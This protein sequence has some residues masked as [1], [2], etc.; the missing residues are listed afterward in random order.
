MSTQGRAFSEAVEAVLEHRSHNGRPEATGERAIEI[1]QQF[2]RTCLHGAKVPDALA[3]AELAPELRQLYQDRTGG[4]ELEVFHFLHDI[5]GAKGI[6]KRVVSE[7]VQTLTAAPNWSIALELCPELLALVE[8]CEADAVRPSLAVISATSEAGVVRPSV[9]SVDVPSDIIAAKWMYADHGSRQSVTWNNPMRWSAK[10]SVEELIGEVTTKNHKSR[11]F[12]VHLYFAGGREE[13]VKC[14]TAAD[15]DGASDDL[16]RL[17]EE[18]RVFV[19]EDRIGIDFEE[20]KQCVV[21]HGAVICRAWYGKVGYRSGRRGRD[22]TAEVQSILEKGEKFFAV[23]GNF[24]DPQP[25]KPKVLY[26][27]YLMP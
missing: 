4:F 18:Q 27:E 21:P 24:G 17:I 19:A 12:F 5:P 7:V 25:G 1:F 13:W 9:A 26:I 3:C 15:E 10:T 16:R 11:P 6:R 2:R 23:N 22:V 8:A 20:S 14:R